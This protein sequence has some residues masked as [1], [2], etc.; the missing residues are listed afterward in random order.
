MVCENGVKDV[1]WVSVIS[2][3]RPAIRVRCSRQAQI[4]L[5]CVSALDLQIGLAR[6]QREHMR[7][8]HS[9][10]GTVRGEGS[11]RRGDVR[12]A[13]DPGGDPP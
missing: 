5:E 12:A 2:H 1:N 13:E 6:E 3:T 4:K 9:D 8:V 11:V 7:I 10:F